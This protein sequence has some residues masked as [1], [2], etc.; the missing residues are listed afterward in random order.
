MFSRERVLIGDKI[1][2]LHNANV[3]IFG[4]GGVGGYALEMLVRAGIEN[5]TI[6]DYDNVDISN[7][8]RQ[9]IA[10]DSTIGKS[11]VS[12]CVD[13]VKDINKACNIVAINDKLTPENIDNFDL[14]N[15]DFIID[16]IDMVTSKI[17]LIK[18]AKENKIPIISAMGVG[19]RFEIPQFEIT[20]IFKTS[21]DGLAKVLRKKL[22]ESGIN[23]HKVVYCKNNAISNGENKVIGSISYYPAISGCMI[24]SYVINELIK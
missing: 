16:A 4:V 18:Y 17:A 14:K 12:V 24:A 21:G 3:I 7:K 9:I 19:N 2:K 23:E 13:R 1:N 11:K 10:L 20:D 5:I 8:N 15:Y 22:R 6:V